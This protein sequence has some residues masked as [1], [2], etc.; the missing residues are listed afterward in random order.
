MRI[1]CAL[2]S[3]TTTSLLPI[4]LLSILLCGCC[5]AD[6]VVD[7]P[8]PPM[9]FMSWERFRC[10]TNC[11]L[12]PHHCIHE[13]LYVSI[14]DALVL[15]GYAAAGYTQVS[16][17][18]CWTDGRDPTTQQLR[19]DP[20]RFPH[21]MA[22]LADYLHA[23]GLLLGIYA[24]AGVETCAHYAGSQHY[25]AVD[26]QTFADWGVDYIKY[27]GCNI[28]EEED[29]DD[30][31]DDDHVDHHKTSRQAFRRVYQAFGDALQQAKHTRPMVYSC[32]W[33][34]YLGT[35][36]SDKPFWDM[37]HDAGCNTWRNYRD[38]TN[39]WA[40]LYDIVHHWADHWRALQAIPAGATN[41][42]D[43][44]V[45]GD[46]HLGR[47]VSHD[48]ARLQLGMWA[49]MASPLFLAGDV[50]T[51]PEADRR[52]LLNRHVLAINQ[53]VSRRQAD[54]VVGCRTTLLDSTVG[55][56]DDDDD[57]DVSDIDGTFMTNHHFI[58]RK[59]S[60]TRAT[61]KKSSDI[62]VWSKSLQQGESHAL[63]FLNLQTN[64][65]E[66]SISYTYQLTG[67]VARC[68]DLWSDN[69][70]A[71]NDEQDVCAQG[72]GNTTQHWKIQRIASSYHHQG[73]ELQIQALN[74]AATSHR[75]LRIDY[76]CSSRSTTDS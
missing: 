59:T 53:D 13:D 46:D 3:I 8:A 43:M 1:L 7:L 60:T 62:Q 35:N 76:F 2:S 61:T 68:I 37:Y 67:A 19:A 48:Q 44:I 32:S 20:D 4:L 10:Q 33:P 12:D 50:R 31:E 24:D 27:D 74:V 41:D 38:I 54:C 40:S 47:F 30:E 55:V 45:A 49:M 51:M 21:G 9:G 23:R 26:A 22:W 39:T 18:D 58:R 75:L 25:E 69:D 17:D 5:S 42:A 15:H 34:A 14:A 29:D 70:D 52:I 36:E 73:F 63:A 6:P 65:T 16:I 72:R 64:T 66:A 28:M 57:M 11:T 71:N 56:D